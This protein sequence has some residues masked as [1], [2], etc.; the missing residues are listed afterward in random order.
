MCRADA[1]AA[2]ADWVQNSKPPSKTPT[3]TKKVT[4]ASK[5]TTAGPNKKTSSA[6]R[7]NP[8]KKVCGGDGNVDAD[9]D[10][11]RRR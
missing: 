3:T 2:V 1:W 7:R 10:Y 4:A 9:G 11:L 5:N 6:S 8:A